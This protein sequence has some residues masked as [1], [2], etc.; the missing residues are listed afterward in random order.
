MKTGFKQFLLLWGT[1]LVSATG[2]G[3]TSF[4]L[5][6][7]IFQET[8]LASLTGLLILL[9]FLPGLLLTPF[10]GIL[11]D[12]IDRR[13]LMMLGDGLSI[14]GLVVILFSI[15]FL[16]SKQQIWGIGSGVAI[17]SVV[18]DPLWNQLFEQRFQIY[19]I[20]RIFQELVD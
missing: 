17:S 14:L 18:F 4:A 10:A 11:A 15:F 20:R 12:R 9:G 19:W 5:G 2:S 16:D 6:I 1:S 3:M 13:L 8:G 7:Y